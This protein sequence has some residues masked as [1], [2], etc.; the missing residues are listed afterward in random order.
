MF[1]LRCSFDIRS[2]LQQL[3]S[4]PLKN[5]VNDRGNLKSQI[6]R[7]GIAYLSVLLG[8]NSGKIEVVGEGLDSGS[9]SHS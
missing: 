8:T 5:V 9:L 3:S 2:I 4:C 7:Y 6:G 1:Q